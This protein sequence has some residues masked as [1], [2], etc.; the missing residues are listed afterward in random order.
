MARTLIL[1]VYC[2]ILAGCATGQRS[3]NPD[4]QNMQSR[5]AFLEDE[6]NAKDQEI[7]SMRNELRQ[8][9]QKYVMKSDNSEISGKR[10]SNK[11]VSK[12]KANNAQLEEIIRVDGVTA[13]KVQLALKKA[14]VYEGKVD[15]K[16][17]P[18]TKEAIKAFQRK[19]NL[20]VDGVVGRGTWAKLKKNL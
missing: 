9:K 13:D 8:V 16:I 19:N 12:T 4:I 1:I 11:A 2:F 3:A 17:G 18:K 20:K 15:G 10:V 7:G 5:I 6:V 14:G